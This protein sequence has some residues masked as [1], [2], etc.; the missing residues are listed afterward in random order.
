MMDRRRSRAIGGKDGNVSRFGRAR[1]LTSLFLRLGRSLALPDE[2]ITE[3]C[4]RDRAH[5]TTVQRGVNRKFTK[6]L[7]LFWPI[8]WAVLQSSAE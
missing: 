3:G 7:D 4:L 2:A 8:T 5:R 1:L 6:T